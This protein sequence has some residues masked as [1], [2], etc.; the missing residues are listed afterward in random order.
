[1]YCKSGI[2]FPIS[3]DKAK[4]TTTDHIKFKNEKIDSPYKCDPTDNEEHCHLTFNI[5]DY[6][7]DVVTEQS[8]IATTCRCAMDGDN[9]FCG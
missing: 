5:T 2:A 6:Q 7:E 3:A 9:G 8:S 4:C 1:M